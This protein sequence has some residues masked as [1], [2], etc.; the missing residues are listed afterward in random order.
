MSY[1]GCM[2]TFGKNIEPPSS[3]PKQAGR[4]VSP[5]RWH[6]AETPQGT[7]AHK[8]TTCFIFTSHIPYQNI[9]PAL[10]LTKTA[11]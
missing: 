2:P 4:S 8:A 10:L 1:F 5:K 6:T 3:G 9:I 7:T 11:F